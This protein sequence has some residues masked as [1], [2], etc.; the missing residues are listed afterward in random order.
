[1]GDPTLT[2]DDF[3]AMLSSDSWVGMEDE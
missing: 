3:V 2:F 1:M